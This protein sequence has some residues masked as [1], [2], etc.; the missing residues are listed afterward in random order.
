VEDERPDDELPRGMPTTVFVSDPSA[1]AERVAQLLRSRG[2]LVADVP[3]AMLV[4]RV[5]VQRPRV[6]LVDADAEGALDALNKMREIPEAE[7][8]DVV[9]FGNEGGAVGSVEGALAQDGS[10]FF[11][12]PVDVPTLLKKLEALTGGPSHG[13]MARPSTPPPSV[14]SMSLEPPPRRPGSLPPPSMR[15]VSAASPPPRGSLNS[16]RFVA[17]PAALVPSFAPEERRSP[18]AQV[19]TELEQLLAE[20]ERRIGGQVTHES[21]FPTPEEEIEAVLPADVLASLDEP[22]DGEE[23]DEPPEIGAHAKGTTS[24]GSRLSTGAGTGAGTNAGARVT[25]PKAPATDPPMPKTHGG[26]THAGTTGN[27]F[28]DFLTGQVPLRSDSPSGAMPQVDSER[29]RATTGPPHQSLPAVTAMDPPHALPREAPIVTLADRLPPPSQLP[30]VTVGLG[31]GPSAPMPSVLAP[32]DAAR[33]VAH[34]I[35]TRATGA[36]CIESQEG[37]RRAVFREGDLVTA[38]SGVDSES[39]LAFLVARGDLPRDDVQG[40]VGKLPPFGRHAGAALVAHGHLR[41]DQL[42][43]VLREHAE[44]IL[45][46]MIQQSTGTALIEVE[47]P[48]RLRGEP[49]VFERSTGAEVFVEVVRRVIAPEDA[50]ARLGGPTSRI[51]DGP[52]VQLESEC[53]LEP[54]IG[55]R[56]QNARG[57]PIQSLLDR[58]PE[59]DVASV[60]YALDLLGVVEMVRAI[61]EARY[62]SPPASAAG[63]DSLDED[64]VRARVRA[65]LQLVEEGDYFALLGVP[66]TA[67]SYEVRRAFVDLRRAFEPARILTPQIADL[68]EDVR[69]IA[70]VLDEAYDILRDN[71]RRERYRRAIEGPSA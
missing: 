35:V 56:I 29:P 50:L 11:K 5:A 23:I 25:S 27:R 21:V 26:G 61:G 28:T 54:S 32:G 33:A 46:R 30:A 9:F 49:S 67:T 69:K 3:L 34:A 57:L 66:R 14:S 1:E 65:R 68:N 64:A 8:I 40:L 48:G 42:W 20:A 10:G 39:L 16:P 52:A 13:P 37:V 12:R 15:D 31:L 24:G 59:P 71:A 19:S 62:P 70:N 60:L 58:S 63:P 44:W 18:S 7:G 41:Q 6:L 45:G 22:I 4:A 53:S 55:E 47:P 36:L 43:S 17:P 38:A 2:Y 51:A